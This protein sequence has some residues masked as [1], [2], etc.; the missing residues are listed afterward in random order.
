V[1]V[2]HSHELAGRFPIR[3]ELAGRTLERVG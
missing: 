3:F 2:T 1:V